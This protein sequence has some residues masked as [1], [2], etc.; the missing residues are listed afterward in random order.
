MRVQRET[1]VLQH[2]QDENLSLYRYFETDELRGLLSILRD[3]KLCPKKN[4]VKLI[5]ETVTPIEFD[6]KETLEMF[7]INAATL[8]E[9]YSKHDAFKIDF[10]TFRLLLNE[11]TEWGKCQ[12]IDLSEKLFRVS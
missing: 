7:E 5:E 12:G 6:K 4:L 3:E 1:V 9:Q 2:Q 10:D 11:L 8:S